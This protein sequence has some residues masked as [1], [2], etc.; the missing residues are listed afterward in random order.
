MSDDVVEVI[1]NPVT[2]EVVVAQA[3]VGGSGTITAWGAITGTL[4]DQAD[5]N[6]ALGGK[7]DTSALGTAAAADVGDFATAAQGAKAD[8]AAQLAA[9]QNFS[10]AQG[11]TPVALTDAATI[12][13]DA[14]LSNVFTVT[15][16]GNRTLGNPT[17]LV[18]GR[19]YAWIVTQGAGGNSL[20]F[21]SYFD[22]PGGTAPTLST[23]AG[24]VD[25]IVG[26]AL[27]STRVLCVANLDF[28]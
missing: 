19:T 23:G 20:A 8:T 15:L 17:N 21:A 27:S 4:S 6:A 9:A 5:L 10:A 22:F 16:G 2:V 7:A 24:A 13:T 12:A 25:L 28:S 18:A 11:V 26:I 14:S 3:V 1:E